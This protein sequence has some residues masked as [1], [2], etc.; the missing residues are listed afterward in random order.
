MMMLLLGR[1]SVCKAVLLAW[2]VCC[3]SFLY[4]S[5]LAVAVGNTLS[6]LLAEGTLSIVIWGVVCV[7]D[8]FAPPGYWRIAR[9]STRVSSFSKKKASS[10]LH[11]RIELSYLGL[12][13]LL[14]RKFSQLFCLR[15]R[16]LLMCPLLICCLLKSALFMELAIVLVRCSIFS[17]KRDGLDIDFDFCFWL[18]PPPALNS[19][20]F[21]RMREFLWGWGEACW[22][23]L[24]V[25]LI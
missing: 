17:D 11:I 6:L 8:W 20:L 13:S 7:S 9:L 15:S 23:L 3:C 1:S 22:N 5:N 25:L 16:S 24:P 10:S 18:V 19:L 4:L 2:Q 12:M 14:Y 21:A